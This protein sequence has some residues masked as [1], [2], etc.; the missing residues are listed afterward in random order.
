MRVRWFILSLVFHLAFGLVWAQ[1]HPPK[2]EFRAAWVCTLANLDWPS[3]AGLPP[4]TQKREF[5]RI[6]DR[7]KAIGMHAVIVQVRPAGDAIYPSKLSPWS[8]YLNGKQGLAPEGG[9]DPLAFMVEECHRRNMEFHAWFNPFRAVSHVRLSSVVPDHPSKRHPEWCYTYGVTKYYDPG[10]PDARSYVIDCIAEV[11]HNYDIDGVHLDDYFYPYP[12]SG[13]ALPDWANW[14]R[15]GEMNT[16]RNDWRRANVDAFVQTLSD[17]LR[18]IN[19]LIK[20]GISPFGVW[21]SQEQDPA[22]SA[23]N[24]TF[25]AYDGLYA[26]T[27]KWILQ[28]WVDYLAPQLYWSINHPRASYKVLL[29]WWKDLGKERHIYIGHG[30]YLMQLA[31]VPV[32]ASTVEFINQAKLSRASPTVGGDIWFRT[33]TLQANPKGI[34]DAL[35]AQHYMHPSIPPSMPWKDSIPPVCPDSLICHPEPEG[36]LLEWELPIAAED[37]QLPHYFMVYRFEEE[38][39]YNLDDPVNILSIQKSTHFFDEKAEKGKSYCYVVTSVD[40][41]HNESIQFAR[42]SIHY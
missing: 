40:R 5:I 23:T 32:W 21:R 26:D 34:A 41:M 27:R 42:R 14:K 31:K 3:K 19:P 28:G 17:S 8:Q 7:L 18:Q 38:A 13:T 37:G 12:I 6:L 4:A 20:F 25:A 16:N 24:K 36:I 2:R 9:F 1:S 39:I 29:E 35:A 11:A 15:F 22:G 30:L 10:H 33:S